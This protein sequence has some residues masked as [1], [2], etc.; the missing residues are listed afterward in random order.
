[1]ILTSS[2]GCSFI[3]ILIIALII[4][5]ILGVIFGI[6]ESLEKL[7]AKIEVFIKNNLLWIGIF[8]LVLIVGG[9]LAKIND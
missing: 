2:A 6:K 8:L 9:V 1:M 7:G 5:S 3:V 4:L